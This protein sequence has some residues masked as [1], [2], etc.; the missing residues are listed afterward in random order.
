MK[1]RFF[2]FSKR[3][4][5]T[6]IPSNTDSYTEVDCAIKD[7]ATVIS[8]KLEIASFNPVAYNY[9]YIP[10][11]KRYY[12]IDDVESVNNMWLVY[13]KEDFLGSF[14]TAI[15]STVCNILYAS[16]STK[17][18]VDSRIPVK[19]D[20]AI[21]HDSASLAGITILDQGGNTI[22]GV[23]G[24][25]S[26]GAYVCNHTNELLDDV[27][28]WWNNLSI[29]SVQDALKQFI[30]GG[31]AADCLKSA[32]KLPINW[33]ETVGI[34]E[35]MVLGGYPCK[36]DNGNAITG[37]RIVNPII[38]GSCNVA[39]PWSTSS[40]L[41]VSQYSS[42]F[43]YLP[44]IGIVSLPAT[45]LQYDSS[46]VVQY[47][48]N[49][50]SGDISVLYTGGTSGKHFGTAS[51]NIAQNTAY[52]S[53]GID[54]NKETQAIVTG[55]GA[56][57]SGAALAATG[58]LS[59]LAAI[60]IGAAYAKAGGDAIAAM[61]GTSG[62]SG[63][64]GGGSCNGLDKDV[65]VWVVT[66]QLAESTSNLDPIIGK[67]YMGVSS[68]NNFSGFVQTDGFRLSG[69]DAYSQEKEEI[70]RLMDSGIYYE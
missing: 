3:L 42:V 48:I 45:E 13:L 66:K 33:T 31:S 23:T 56:I 68:P 12:F 47:K 10:T 51:G 54:T 15:G 16:G 55:V 65:H 61:G 5:S 53:T 36:D 9:A 29:N 14:K 60:G 67:P 24:K 27:D 28:N 69:A 20:V 46:I 6:K 7:S 58:A 17:N 35:N 8:P 62:G 22:V 4:N 44:L 57:V 52:G 41:R 2:A 39:I 43:M 49:I 11:W 70:T 19:A 25:G 37:D 18:I 21:S 59:P 30:Y 64:L 63:G 26:F 1:V 50:T 34:T 40:W 32:I 38:S